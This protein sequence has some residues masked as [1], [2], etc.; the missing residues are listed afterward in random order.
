M[1]TPLLVAQSPLTAATPSPTYKEP[2]SETDRP[3]VS[4][5]DCPRTQLIA[6]SPAQLDSPVLIESP[7]SAEP[8]PQDPS[9][10]RRV[11]FSLTP[12]VHEY[13]VERQFPKTLSPH[14]H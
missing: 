5:E 12:Q 11:S 13:V 4:E 8:S 1:N 9:H 2:Q 6:S 14:V 3:H 7:F 10:E